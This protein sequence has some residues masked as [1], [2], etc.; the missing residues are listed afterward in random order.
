MASVTDPGDEILVCRPYYTNYH[1]YAHML[2]IETSPVTTRTDDHYRIHPA[3]IEE[4]ITGK[5]RALVLDTREPHGRGAAHEDL[6]KIAEICKRRG[7]FFICDEVYREFIYD[8]PL[9][10]TRTIPVAV[11]GARTGH[12]HRLGLQAIQRVRCEGRLPRHSQQGAQKGRTALRSGSPLA[13]NGRSACG[14]GCDRH[15]SGLLP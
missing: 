1:G 4:A 12:H 7:L 10:T 9:G 5:T 11:P 13:G 2:G 8:A 6:V 14:H 15:A 3:K